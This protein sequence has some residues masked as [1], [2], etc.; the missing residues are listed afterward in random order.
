MAMGPVRPRDTPESSPKKLLSESV[1]TQGRMTKSTDT[2]MVT[3]LLLKTNGPRGDGWEY[4]RRLSF[5]ATARGES[6]ATLRRLPELPAD[7][8]STW[9]AR[10]GVA[11]R[12]IYFDTIRS[13]FQQQYATQIG[14]GYRPSGCRRPTSAGWIESPP[15]RRSQ[16]SMPRS[17]RRYPRQRLNYGPYSLMGCG[18]WETNTSR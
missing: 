2:G 14:A 10:S 5:L 15:W 11:I 9:E 16:R 7:Q 8:R 17:V 13:R 1:D 6:P 4:R 3:Q 18:R 12:L